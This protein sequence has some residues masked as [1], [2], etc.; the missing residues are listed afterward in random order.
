LLGGAFGLGISKNICDC[1]SFLVNNYAVGDEIFLFGFSRGA[2]TVRSL[3]GFI[4]NCGLLRLEHAERIPEAYALYR[5]RSA[6]THP[7]EKLAQQFRDKYAREV[8]IK[9]LGVWDTVG[10]LGIPMGLLNRLFMR[11]YQFHDV[12]VPFIAQT[13][14]G[15]DCCHRNGCRLLKRE[16]GR[17]QHQCVFSGTDIP[18]KTAM[19]DIPKHLITWLKLLDI[20]ANRFNPARYVSAGYGVFG[21]EQPT[22]HEANQEYVSGQEMPVI[23]IEG[24]RINLYECLIVLRGRFFHLFELKNIGWP[25]F[26]ADNRF[27]AG[28]LLLPR[29]AQETVV[30]IC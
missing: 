3:A 24:G 7:R 22:A 12:Y 14:Q 23:C 1:Y 6:K 28:L 30:S 21:F 20:S 8:R 19:G 13:L 9:C 2:Y 11:Q 16:I 17:F 18:G 4:R 25:I 27:H 5:D 15:G 10:S 26:C 29:C